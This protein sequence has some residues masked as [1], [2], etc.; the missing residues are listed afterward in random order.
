M[1]YKAFFTFTAIYQAFYTFGGVWSGVLWT[2]YFETNVKSVVY[3]TINILLK[4]RTTF[5]ESFVVNNN[6]I[7][8]INDDHHVN[9]ANIAQITQYSKQE[10]CL[11]KLNYFARILNEKPFVYQIL[12]VAINRESAKVFVGGFVVGKILSLMWNTVDLD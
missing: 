5:H 3:Q 1:T 9:R 12:G 10:A 7:G 4:N 11:E 6:Q 2:E 8:D